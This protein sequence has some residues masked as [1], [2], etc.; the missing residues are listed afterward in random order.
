MSPAGPLALIGWW[1]HEE[2]V[3]A[4]Q[5]S[6]TRHQGASGRGLGE[7]IDEEGKKSSEWEKLDFP[8]QG[9]SRC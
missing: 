6:R 9:G 4:I 7:A 1:Q 3:V 5:D 2:N 8:V